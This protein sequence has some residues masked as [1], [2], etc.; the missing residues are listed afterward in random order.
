MREH[1]AFTEQEQN[2][3]LDNDLLRNLKV[4]GGA[5]ENWP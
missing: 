1:Y 3:M 5:I 4:L 2:D